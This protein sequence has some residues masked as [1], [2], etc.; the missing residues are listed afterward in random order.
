MTATAPADGSAW[1]PPPGAGPY[2]PGACVETGTGAVTCDRPHHFEIMASGD[3]PAD[4]RAAYP[5]PVGPLRPGCTVALT[6]YLGSVDAEASRLE[7]LIMFPTRDGWTAGERWYACLVADRGPDSGWVHRTGNLGGALVGGLG[8]F[9]RCLVGEPITD[10]EGVVDCD[11]PHR[12][13]AVP[14]VLVLGGPTDPPPPDFQRLLIDRVLPHCDAAVA[15]YL[16]GGR[17]G[18]RSGGL[19]PLA[20]NWAAG[21][22]TAVCYAVADTPTSGVMGR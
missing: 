16:G 2:R 21:V 10:P 4:L 8:A 5:P 11:Q 22:R 9:Q 3:L 12:S 13:E 14:G 19:G 18:V 20:G 17:P 6:R 7:A 15:T 1:E